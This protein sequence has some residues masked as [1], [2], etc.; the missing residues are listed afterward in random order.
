MERLQ[1]FPFTS[2]YNDYDEKGRPIYDRAVGSK[3]LRHAFA[4]FFSSGIFPQPSDNLMLRRGSGFDV[5]VSYGEAIID[6]AFGGVDDVNGKAFT[7]MTEP[8]R[9][10]KTYAFF[11]RLDDNFDKRSLYIRVAE[12][13]GSAPAEP[14]AVEGA[15]SELRLGY[16]TFPSNAASVEDA[17]LVDERG[18]AVCPY[19]APF[20]DIDVSHILDEVRRTA[21]MEL[22][23]FMRILSDNLSFIASAIDG[24]AAGNLQA[25]INQLNMDAVRRSNLDPR[26]L[27]DA[28]TGLVRLAEGAVDGKT[29]EIGTNNELRVK[30]GSIGA[31]Q[32]DREFFDTITRNTSS[33]PLLLAKT[34]LFTSPKYYA[35]GIT[36][37]SGYQ[38]THVHNIGDGGMVSLWVYI[39]KSNP[40]MIVIRIYGKRS[41]GTIIDA[42]HVGASSSGRKTPVWS[43]NACED[44][45]DVYVHLMHSSMSESNVIIETIKVTHDNVVEVMPNRNFEIGISSMDVVWKY[46]EMSSDV[47]RYLPN[48]FSPYFKVGST[49]YS[50][51]MD[52]TETRE[53]FMILSLD[54]NGVS[55]LEKA[56]I[57]ESYYED[58]GFSESETIGNY[59]TD[60][61]SVIQKDETVYVT[62]VEDNGVTGV[63]NVSKVGQIAINL[64][65]KNIKYS[66]CDI[67]KI[68][69][70]TYGLA[71]PYSYKLFQ[72]IYDLTE[73]FYTCYSDI[74][75]S[76]IVSEDKAGELMPF[77]RWYHVNRIDLSFEDSPGKLEYMFDTD[78]SLDRDS[79]NVG[80]RKGNNLVLASEA[81]FYYIDTASSGNYIMKH[82]NEPSIS[83]RKFYPF[84]TLLQG[85]TINEFKMGYYSTIKNNKFYL[86][87]DSILAH[88]TW[89]GNSTP[90]SA[91]P[92]KLDS[93]IL[94]VVLD[95]EDL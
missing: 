94:R 53:K 66:F 54:E 19:A 21:G 3:M 10:S 74:N 48:T 47:H 35:S 50:V 45:S 2:V 37:S 12:T 52:R 64:P 87:G 1:S 11:V 80:L 46:L 79:T 85:S 49:S 93:K 44:G 55:T 28:G 83:G 9:G 32:I 39:Q 86:F 15:V 25:Q 84:S 24:T 95:M 89:V 40:S 69:L 91:I 30:D 23:S 56:S 59:L 63:N 57:A 16:V 65:E 31:T 75:Y 88:C 20:E 34:C 92:G 7:L 82:E 73:F 72:N 29:I 90:N 67:P 18:L 76:N 22:D 6:G 58:M 38:S 42:Y 71:G 68:E 51:F 14:E 62:G 81:S 41:D 33:N 17:T 26:N 27:T 36:S 43:S 4:Q 5:V 13:A 70:D 78:G 77:T 61:M 60:C 8:P